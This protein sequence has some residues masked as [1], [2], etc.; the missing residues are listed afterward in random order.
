MRLLFFAFL[1]PV[2]SEIRVQEPLHPA[3]EDKRQGG[4]ICYPG[5]LYTACGRKKGREHL[6]CCS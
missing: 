5:L 4:G 1:T 6:L 2:C 3:K